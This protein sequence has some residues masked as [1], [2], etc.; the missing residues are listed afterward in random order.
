MKLEAEKKAKAEKVKTKA[1]LGTRDGGEKKEL[2]VTE[3]V[4]KK[5]P[6]SSGVGSICQ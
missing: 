2:L 6:A 5:K 1:I 4:K 3:E